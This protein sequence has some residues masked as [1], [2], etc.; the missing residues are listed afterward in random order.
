MIVTVLDTETTSFDA[1]SGRMVEF[2]GVR[3]KVDGLTASYIDETSFIINPGV[4]IP[5]EASAVHHLTDRHVVNGMKYS[6]ALGAIEEYTADSDYVVAHNSAFDSKFVPVNKPWLCTLRLAR[7]LVESPAYSNQVLRYALNLNVDETRLGLLAPHRALYDVIVTAELFKYLL[8]KA[9]S[10]EALAEV[11]NK[12]VLIKKMPFGK[13]KG[14]AFEDI[15]LDYLSYMSKGT[16]LDSDLK[17]T[18]DHH[19]NQKKLGGRRWN[20]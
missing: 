2:A 3:L 7:H 9:G 8:L 11:C 12:P 6:L 4:S 16:D 10:L 18:I 20:P 14:K 1:K 13:Y 5:P 17:A 15:P 19:M